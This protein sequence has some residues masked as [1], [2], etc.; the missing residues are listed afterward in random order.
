ME[1]QLK[2]PLLPL[3]DSYSAVERVFATRGIA[4]E[5]I[6]HYLNTTDDDILPPESIPNMN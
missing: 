4:P 1:Y 3:K 2:T 6:E 5:N